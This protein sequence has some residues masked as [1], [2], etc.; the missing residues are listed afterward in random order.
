MTRAISRTVAVIGAGIAGL[1]CARRLVERGF[2]VTVFERADVPGGRVATLRTE[3][4]S[5]DHGAQYFTARHPAFVAQAARW[6]AAG[7][8]EPWPVSVQNIA[9]AA[10]KQK[11][12]AHSNGGTLRWV[13]VPGM[14]AIASHLSDGLDLRFDARIVQLDAVS[15]APGRPEDRSRWSLRRREGDVD[16][17]VAVT[18]GLF[19]AVVIAVP[20]ESAAV[21]LGVAPALA[22]QAAGARIEPCWALLLGFTEPIEANVMNDVAANAAADAARVG[23][24]AFI[25]SGRLAWIARESSKPDRRMGERWTAHAQSAWSTEHFDD[26]P[27][28]VKAKMLRAFHEATG[29]A[30]QP[31]YAAVYR[32]RHALARTPLARDLLWDEH[33]RVGACGDWCRGH[34]IEDAWLSGAALAEAMAASN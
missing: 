26:D 8:V 13:G 32:W 6:S 5:F 11:A 2:S 18:E 34:R 15:A 27:E 12:H 10:G 14:S 21:L 7:I 23:D 22:R 29:T 24:A 9:A 4:G 16:S 3:I 28:D 19:D 33:L 31:V 25:D 17:H 1:S 20:A 30:E